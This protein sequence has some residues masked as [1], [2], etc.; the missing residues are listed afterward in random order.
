MTKADIEALS[1]KAKVIVQL[2]VTEFLKT[3]KER[4]E[5]WKKDLTNG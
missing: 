2:D 1:K 4:A 5:K 3:I